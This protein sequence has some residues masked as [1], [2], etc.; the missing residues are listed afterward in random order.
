[1]TGKG[2]DEERN[3]AAAEGSVGAG[4]AERAR[5]GAQ[6]LAVDKEVASPWVSIYP[7]V[8]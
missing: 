8:K 2:D 7:T 6:S 3:G 5:A 4:V 1:M